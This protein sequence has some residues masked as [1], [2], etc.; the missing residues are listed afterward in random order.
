M[1]QSM[2]IRH[3]RSVSESA[4]RDGRRKRESNSAG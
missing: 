3:Y 4:E 1:G 2:T